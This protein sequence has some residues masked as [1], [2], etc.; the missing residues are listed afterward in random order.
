MSLQS[1][2]HLTSAHPRYD[3]RIFVKECSSLAEI[4]DTYLIVADGKGNEIVNGVSILDAGKFS[5]RLNRMINAPNA[6]YER[7]KKLDADLYHLHDPELIPIGLKLK[8]LGKKVIFDAHE[9]LPNQVKSKHYIPK[10]LRV[11]LPSMVRKF[12][13]YTCSRFDGVV[14]AAEPVIKDKFLEINPKT[15]VINNF[16]LLE[17]LASLPNTNNISNQVCYVGG[18]AETRGIVELVK[19]VKLSKNNLKLVI[20]GDFPTKELEV[21]VGKIDGWS[22]VDF[23][24]YVDRQSISDILEKSCVGMVTLHPTPS[25]LNSMPIKLFEYMAAG[26]PVVASNFPLWEVIINNTGC[27]LCVDPLKPQQIAEAVDYFIDNPIKAIEMGNKGRQAVL[28]K[29]NWTIEKNKLFEFY[30]TILGENND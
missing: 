19:S 5:G 26:I 16:P 25:Y 10:P 12:E 29:Y 22:K 11:L 8:K 18:L 4:Y 14:V 23:R 2:V 7:A 21:K 6:V 3:T 20:A 13:E 27:G 15:I 28:K 24:G 17:E 9:D 30:N 1:V